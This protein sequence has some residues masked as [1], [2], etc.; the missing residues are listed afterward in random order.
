[1]TASARLSKELI[2]ALTMEEIEAEL[3]RALTDMNNIRAQIDRAKAEQK[4]GMGYSDADWF[5][6]ANTALHIRGREHQNL[7][8]EFK[9]KRK[10]ANE[11]KARA[12][13]ATFERQFMLNAKQILPPET[14]QAIMT[15]TQMEVRS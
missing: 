2:A 12:G 1:M 7:Q 5:A 13:N 4:Q 14:Y 15:M 10:E 6:R 8:L 9:R 11:A 3:D